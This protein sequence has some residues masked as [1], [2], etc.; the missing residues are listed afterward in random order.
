MQRPLAHYA[1]TLV[2]GQLVEPAL[3]KARIE[4][5]A[6]H[7]GRLN[8]IAQRRQHKQRA[9]YKQQQD[10]EEDEDYHGAFLSEGGRSLAKRCFCAADNAPAGSLRRAAPTIT[11]VAPAPTNSSGT[12]HNSRVSG[13]NGG[14]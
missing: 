9:C 4:L 11:T 12:S 14:V 5:I 10:D 3:I 13:F 2:V 8:A 7:G 1:F 6:A